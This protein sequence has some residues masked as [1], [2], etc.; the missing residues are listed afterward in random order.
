[1]D[2]MSLLATKAIGLSA[3]W[4]IRRYLLER[5]TFLGSSFLLLYVLR[6]LFSL[7]PQSFA[8]ILTFA[9]VNVSTISHKIVYQ[10]YEE[11]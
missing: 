5:V 7:V 4:A 3:F 8:T 1:M 2:F 10:S 9:Y 11:L 6:L